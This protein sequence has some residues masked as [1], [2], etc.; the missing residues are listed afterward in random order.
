MR[1]LLCSTSFNNG[2]SNKPIDQAHTTLL[3]ESTCPWAASSSYRFT[4]SIALSRWVLGRVSAIVRQFAFQARARSEL[5]S[6]TWR[7]VAILGARTQSEAQI[8]GQQKGS[9]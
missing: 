3:A 7:K 5:L 4:T 1:S 6:S 2:I 9:A 8:D